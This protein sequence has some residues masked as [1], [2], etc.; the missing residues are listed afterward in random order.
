MR[1]HRPMQDQHD[2]HPEPATW[3]DAHAHFLAEAGAVLA[4]PLDDEQLLTSLAHLAVP[5][6]AD[7]CA[8][9][10]ADADGHLRRVALVCADPADEPVA[11]AMRRFPLRPNLSNVYSQAYADGQSELLEDLTPEFFDRAIADEPYR[12]LI[13][14]IAPRSILTV[15]LIVRGAPRGAI[16]FMLAASGRRHTTE[17]CRLAEEL[18]RRAA[19]AVEN[20]QLYRGVRRRVAELATMQRVARAAVSALRLDQLCQTVVDQ[21]HQAFGYQLVSIYLREGDSL[22]LQA[23]VG[24]DAVLREIRLDQGVSGRVV[25]T[26]KPAFVRDARTDPDFI[27]VM[28]GI[29]QGIII[30]LHYA[31]SPVLGTI[32]VESTGEPALDEGDLAILK[33]LADQ[34]SVAVVNARLFAR[35]EESATRFS[36]LV[37][38]AGS[39]IFCLD[40]ALHITEFNREAERV[41]GASRAQVLGS[42]YLERFVDLHERAILGDLAHRAL[43]GETLAPFEWSVRMATGEERSFVWTVSCRRDA[44]G[45]PAELFIVG[46]D[47]TRLRQAEEARLALERKMFEAQRLESLGVL[48]GGIA[49]DFNNMLAAILGNASLLLLDLPPDSEAAHAAR[50]IELVTQR[51]AD[52]VGQMLAYAGRGRFNIQPLDLNELVA[53]M[54]VLL[55]VSVAKGAVL[56]QHLTPQLPAIEADAAQVR[57][58]V[59]NLIVNASEALDPTGGTVT[60]TT[61]VREIDAH[62]SRQ[63]FVTP[64]LAPGPYVCLTVEDN[65]IGMSEATIARIFD[66]F[67]TTKFTGRGLGLAAVLGIVRAHRGALAVSS[68]LGRGT[69]FTVLFPASGVS[70]DPQNT[71]LAPALVPRPGITRPLVLVIEDEDDV[72]RMVVRLLERG[73]Y[74]A[75]GAADGESALAL[76]RGIQQPIAAV[77]L[78][79]TM[80]HLGGEEVLRAL[81]QLRPGLPVVLMSG[82]TTDEMRLRSGVGSAAAFVHKP[83]AAGELLEVL[84]RVIAAAARS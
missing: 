24:Y 82:Y 21:I 12:A 74:T 72:R 28:P 18:V 26:G 76:C 41:F 43:S 52:L 75:L 68:T 60:I 57:Q 33:L 61:S 5:F 45:R 3:S 40:P 65:G 55:R 36:S 42:H 63:S 1:Y 69:T 58:V 84:A 34:I 59:M 78:D 16:T 49:H 27:A 30:P 19:I 51:A 22:H 2:A 77:L 9:A 67:F 11:E 37:E 64:D 32:S 23:Y 48:A 50:Q 73:G 53:E 8:V 54:I 83:F 56:V 15:P 35:V 17:S 38:T 14:R 6:L 80:P 20:A 79:L 29:N 44:T 25:R 62:T 66:P 31:G 81:Q 71:P 13:K 70:L 4:A 39:V 7:W 46:Q 10:L 47:V